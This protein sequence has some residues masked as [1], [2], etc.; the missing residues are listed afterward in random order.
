MNQPLALTRQ[1]RIV[2]PDAL[3]TDRNILRE[4]FSRELFG[5]DASHNDEEKTALVE[6][7]VDMHIASIPAYLEHVNQA[8]AELEEFLAEIDQESASVPDWLRGTDLFGT[9][10]NQGG[11][12]RRRASRPTRRRRR[13]ISRR[14]R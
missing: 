14:R 5:H 9:Q 11:R 3:E 13:S 7:W 6:H 1:R 2:L 8:P 4:H 10:P 12:R